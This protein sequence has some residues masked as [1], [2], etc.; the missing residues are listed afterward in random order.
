[1]SSERLIDHLLGLLPE[2]EE[3]AL[4]RELAD[5]PALQQE[6]S[7]LREA[8]Y[9]LAEAGRIEAAPAAAWDAIRSGVRG[10]E[11]RHTPLSAP[12]RRWRDRA[13]LA[14]A[15]ALVLTTGA[16]LA[17]GGWQRSR[18]L[19]LDQEQSVLAYWMLHPDVDIVALDPPQGEKRNGI[20][21]LLPEGRTLL[22]QT[23]PPSS[24]GIYRV[25]GGSGADRTLIGETNGRMLVF[26]RTPFDRIEVE[27]VSRTVATLVGS[28]ELER[29]Y[30]HQYD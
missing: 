30:K 24:G 9:A 7:G 21:C 19:R 4:L 17:W 28:T 18:A 22:L 15:A 23:H 8:F 16:S 2:D 3:Q 26:D 12:P 14:L 27:R 6:L 5:S 1:M 11:D 25:W 29:G 10:S 20:V 13:L